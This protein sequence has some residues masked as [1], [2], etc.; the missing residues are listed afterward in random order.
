VYVGS[1]AEIS[2]QIADLADSGH[3][4]ILISS[5]NPGLIGTADRIIAFREG[6]LVATFEKGEATEDALLATTMG[7]DGSASGAQEMP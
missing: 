2:R 3:T 5:Y 6:R 1:T 4:I 7:G